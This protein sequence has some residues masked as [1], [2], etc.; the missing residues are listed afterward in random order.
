VLG[1]SSAH[2]VQ[3]INVTPVL[4][5]FLVLKC[6]RVENGSTA[7]GAPIQGSPCDSTN[8]AF[9]FARFGQ[10]ATFAQ[11]FNWEGPRIQGIGTTFER[12][13]PGGKCLDVLGG[14]TADLTPVILFDCNLTSAQQWNFS[15]GRIINVRSGKCLDVF[16]NGISVR[17]ARIRTCGGISPVGQ[18][19]FIR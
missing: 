19:W 9:S 1:I 5:N 10:D 13:P 12:G 6:L 3:L 14:G 7:N 2:A 8:S 18:L 4:G 17:Q 16:D 15:N 11:E